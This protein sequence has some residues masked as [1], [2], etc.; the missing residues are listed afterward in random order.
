MKTPRWS[1][2]KID[3]KKCLQQTYTTTT[4]ESWSQH[5]LRNYCS[6]PSAWG[7]W[8]ML[9][10]SP[11]FT[12]SAPPVYRATSVC[13]RKGSPKHWSSR[14]SP[15]PRA[16]SGLT[17]LWEGLLIFRKISEW[18]KWRML[19]GNGREEG[20]I[21]ESWRVRC[22]SRTVTALW[23]TTVLIVKSICVPNATGTMTLPLFYQ[24]TS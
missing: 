7:N 11:V 21:R 13:L 22:A 2:L 19:W 12:P 14:D 5:W 8:T 3:L 6:V 4:L 23:N 9:M 20:A 18:S 17:P 24:L 16:E 15:A 1:F 10:L